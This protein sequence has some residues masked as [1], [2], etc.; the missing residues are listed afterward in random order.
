[1]THFK[2]K[3]MLAVHAALDTLYDAFDQTVKDEPDPK[4]PYHP[5]EV[6]EVEWVLRRENLPDWTVIWSYAS[7]A[8]LREM[9]RSDVNDPYGP[10]PVYQSTRIKPGA[11]VY[12][13]PPSGVMAEYAPMAFFRTRQ[14]M[15]KVDFIKRDPTTKI[16]LAHVIPFYH[17]PAAVR[18]DIETG[19]EEKSEEAFTSTVI[20]LDELVLLEKNRGKTGALNFFNDYLRAKT[21]KWRRSL[22]MQHPI[23]TFTGIVDARHALVE[24]DIFWNDALPYFAMVEGTGKPGKRFGSLSEHSICITVQYPQ[25]FT[26]IG[27]DDVLDN[28]NS[29]YYNLWQ[30]L[31]DGAKCICSSGTNA[32]WD[33]SN[34]AFEFCTTSR[35]EDLGTSHEYIP[36]CAAVY[37]CINV[38]LGIAKQTEDFLEALYRWSAGPLELLWPGFLQ[39]K[40]LK[41][42]IIVAIPTAL[43]ALAS[44]NENSYWYYAYLVM[45]G[46]FMVVAYLDRRAGRKPLRSFIVSTVVSINLFIVCSNLMSVMWY[47]IFP[48]RIAFYGLLPMGRSDQQGLFWGWISIFV[49]IP[50]GIVH[51][52]LIRMA[53]HTAPATKQMNYHKCLWR[54]AQ[55]Y[56]N[57]FMFTALATV[58]G[59][60]SA[61]KAYAWDYDL[62]MWTSFRIPDSEYDKLNKSV[63][64]VSICSTAFTV[65]LYRYA[66]LY[67]SSCLAALTMPTVM[68]KWYVTCVFLLQ[69]VCIAVS[70]FVVNRHKIIQLAVV[71]FTCGINI[72]MTIEVALLLQPVFKIPLGY[73]FRAEYMFGIL[74]AVILISA[75]VNHALNIETISSRVRLE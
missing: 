13:L 46:L 12:R 38:A 36:H 42:F 19:Q 58:A 16:Q 55:L 48:S 65:Y 50:A 67:L 6:S 41:H 23:Q 33:I 44:F 57:S 43:M 66:R 26:N 5:D 31:R 56:A 47:I 7:R 35:S 54:G 18:T 37:L 20:P 21:Y 9:K 60:W 3:H 45:V 73:P 14:A 34:P 30:T 63:A 29:T 39:W 27:T 2:G 32:I 24:T 75:L 64:N 11:I 70:T 8:R 74:G 59:S 72:L 25:F 52:A 69:F 51:D 62:S 22:G 15:Y 1:M 49:S 28:S 68:T 61:Y 4:R 53:R 17:S 71:L 40:I 10:D